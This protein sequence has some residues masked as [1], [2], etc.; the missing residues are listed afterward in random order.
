MSWCMKCPD[1]RLLETER[2][3]SKGEGVETFEDV[4]HEKQQQMFEEDGKDGEKGAVERMRL[5][6]NDMSL[7]VFHDFVGV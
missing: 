1:V 2:G 6:R 3:S 5:F 4:D 7:H